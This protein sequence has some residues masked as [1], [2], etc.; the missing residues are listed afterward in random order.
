MMGQKR[1]GAGS[2]L[3]I[4]GCPRK[5]LVILAKRSR[6]GD[7]IAES[8]AGFVR[9]MLSA[10]GWSGAMPPARAEVCGCWS[11]QKTYYLEMQ[12]P[13]PDC[14]KPLPAGAQLLPVQ[15]AD[16][17]L[18]QRL[19]RAVGSPWGWTDKAGWPLARWQ[20]YVAGLGEAEQPLAEPEQLA[21]CR[22]VFDGREAGYFELGK[23][24]GEV[25]IRYFG[26][27]PW[28][29]GLG[30]GAGLLSAAVEQAWAWGATRVW[31]HTCDLDHPAALGNYQR[32]GFTLYRTETE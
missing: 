17:Q 21:T 23:V 2:N 30:L 26:L 10:A 24:K 12:N 6:Q 28:A 4:M 29:I 16:A 14:L 32:R 3:E 11:V 18:N 20:Q 5:Y 25:E 1:Q 22:L 7:V 19:Y 13:R 27:L 9:Y 31:V 15:P 8:G